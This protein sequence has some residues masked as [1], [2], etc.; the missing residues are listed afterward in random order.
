MLWFSLTICA[1]QT[2]PVINLFEVSQNFQRTSDSGSW[3]IQRLD[4]Q[5]NSNSTKTNMSG[6]QALLET[7]PVLQQKDEMSRPSSPLPQWE[8]SAVE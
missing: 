3:L 1:Y 8:E 4:Q 6:D 2:V 5:K 7:E